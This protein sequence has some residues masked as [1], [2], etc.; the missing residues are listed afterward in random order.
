M[1]VQYTGKKIAQLRKEK[2][3]TQKIIAEKLHVSVAAVSKWERGLNYPDLSLMEP[4]ADCLGISVS[5][6]L[7]LKN[8]SADKVIKDITEI[9]NNEKEVL[10]QTL[11]KRILLILL[12]TTLFLIIIIIIA[13]IGRDTGIKGDIPEFM[14]SGILQIIPLILGFTAWGLAVTSILSTGKGFTE[15]CKNYSMLSIGCCSISLYFPVL[16]TDLTLRFGDFTTI[17]D[18]IWAYNYA[19]IVLLSGTI[20]LNIC[21][22]IIHGRK[23]S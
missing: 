15:K 3:W 7:G 16:I 18:T 12:I 5:E 8:E 22:W 9:S 14:N 11:W 17:D 13:I 23:I 20:L 1:D 10:H 2:G 4:L 6:L 19:S 21:S